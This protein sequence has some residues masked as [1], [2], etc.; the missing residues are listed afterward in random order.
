MLELVKEKK[1]GMGRARG[2]KPPVA[3]SSFSSQS[4]CNLI[5]QHSSISNMF[6]R[7]IFLALFASTA[8]VAANPVP[9]DT[10]PASQCNTGPIQ[11][12]NQVQ[13][14]SS[15]RVMHTDI[16]LTRSNTSQANSNSISTLLALL[17]ISV[18]DITGLVGVS[19]SPISVVGIGGNS[20]SAQP[21]CCS[22]NNFVSYFVLR[23]SNTVS[24]EVY[25]N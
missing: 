13:S 19:C 1:L 11:C 24:N 25:H 12:C 22:N 21:V 9:T 16:I 5:L 10:I 17:G 8:F 6:S 18:G 23:I 20:C 2:Y 7:T 15:H 4:N 3:C 14:V